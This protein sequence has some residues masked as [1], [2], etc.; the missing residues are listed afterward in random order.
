MFEQPTAGRYTA[1]RFFIL[2][3]YAFTGWT[4]P[5][6]GVSIGQQHGTAAANP[7]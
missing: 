7:C 3:T 2:P 1:C 4:C 6:M 5:E